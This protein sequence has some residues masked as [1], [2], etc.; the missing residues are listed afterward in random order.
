MKANGFKAAKHKV[1]RALRDGNFQHEADRKGVDTK[2]LLLTGAVS[3]S[4]ICA[5][6][7]R[8]RG[9]DHQMSPHHQ[10]QDITVHV[11]TREGWY[12]KFY[13]IDPDTIFI[14]VHK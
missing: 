2:N 5:I 14:S 13:F 7:E 4:E 8:A 6:L 12:V 3:P 1:I 10:A 9:T 11:I